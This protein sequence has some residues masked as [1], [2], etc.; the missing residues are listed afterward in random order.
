MAYKEV[1]EYYVYA[2]GQSFVLYEEQLRFDA[3]NVLTEHFNQPHPYDASKSAPPLKLTQ[4]PALFTLIVRYLS[5]YNFLPLP[6]AGLPSGI[7][8]QAALEGL[9]RDAERL[10]L[11]GLVRLL[12]KHRLPQSVQL[13]SCNWAGVGDTI[14][15]LADLVDEE[16]EPTEGDLYWHSRTE[17]LSGDQ[18][19]PVL[20]LAR[21]VPVR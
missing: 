11:H 12:K 1:K 18:G 15:E 6:A 10:R 19:L 14:V 4:D 16:F 13:K 3:P 20:V 2:Q 8:V 7:S 9:L 21:D 5:G 17:L